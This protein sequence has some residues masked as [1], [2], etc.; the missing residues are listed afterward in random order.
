MCFQPIASTFNTPALLTFSLWIS[1]ADDQYIS[2]CAMGYPAKDK[3]PS[4][5]LN[6]SSER[7]DL[8]FAGNVVTAG[9]ARLI[10]EPLCFC[11][12][13]RSAAAH[14]ITWRGRYVND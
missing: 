6:I 8:V 1:A 4:G 13:C 10:R 2:Q 14:D 11:V 3:A 5:W 9:V 12:F 7:H